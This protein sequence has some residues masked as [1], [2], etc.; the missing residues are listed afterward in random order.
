MKALINFKI[1]DNSPECGG[2]AICPTG[3]MYYDEEKESVVVDEEKCTCCGLCEN[4]CPIGAIMVPKDE[5]Q[6]KDYQKQIE[7]DPRTIKDLFVDRYGAASLSDFFIINPEEIESKIK[8]GITLIE[9]YMEESIQ[10]LLKSIPIKEITENIT[11]N[12]NYYKVEDNNLFGE[13]YDIKEYPSLLIFKDSKYLGKIEG[14]Y[15]VDQ[16]EK[17]INL[18]KDII[19]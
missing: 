1:C 5:E 13:K 2:V 9:V 17:F 18:L 6:Y 19:N 15:E 16:K 10:C 8:N 12:I 7:D 4:E 14:Y 11:G 3:A